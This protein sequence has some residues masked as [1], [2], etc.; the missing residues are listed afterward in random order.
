MKYVSILAVVIALVL[1]FV[2]QKQ[3]S[4]HDAARNHKLIFYERELFSQGVIKANK[5]TV[6]PPPHIAGGIIPHHLLPSTVL[7]KFF[8]QLQFQNPKRIILLGP[9]HGELGAYKVISSVYGWETPFGIVQP[10]TQIVNDLVGEKL[11]NINEDVIENEH[12]VAGIMPY[13]KFYLPN[14]RVIPLILRS[15]LTQQEAQQLADQ[16]VTYEDSQTIIIA[17]VDFSH[18]LNA[19]EAEQKDTVT[20]QA[21]KDFNFRKMWSMNSDYTDSPQSLAV[22]LMAMK[23]LGKGNVIELDHTNSGYMENNLF[24]ETTSYFTLIFN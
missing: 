10:D 18:Y 21:M 8:R 24:M 3:T 12:S 16:L 9:N 15:T 22:V 1:V 5:N 19:S 20:Y 14:A 4:Q 6:I 17:A 11:S 7:S 2:W 13:I 23:K